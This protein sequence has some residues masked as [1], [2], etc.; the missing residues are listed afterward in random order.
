MTV[1]LEVELWN[2]SAD[3]EELAQCIDVTLKLARQAVVD[4]CHFER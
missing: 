4:N 1:E 2:S 3:I